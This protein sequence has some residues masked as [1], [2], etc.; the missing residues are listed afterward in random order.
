MWNKL[1]KRYLG[2]LLLAAAV[3][4]AALFFLN[5]DTKT[6]YVMR[7]VRPETGTARTVITSTGSVQP[8]NRLEIKPPIGGRIE[9]ILV[10]E[11]DRVKA[12]TVVA[13]MSSTERAALL[14]AA[15]AQ[16]AEA[17]KYWE[18]AYKPTPLLAPISGDVI[19][20]AVE[21]G[22]TVTQTDAVVVLSDRLIIKAQMD[23][24]DIGRVRLG[25][26][27]LISLD[28]YPEIS[29]DA[30]VDH[31]SFESKVVNN[32]TMYEVDVVPERVP[33]VFRSGMSA[34]VKIIEKIKENA[35]LLPREAVK[36]DSDGSFVHVRKENGRIE[37][38][39]VVTGI[40]EDG[41]MEITGGLSLDDVVIIRSEPSAAPKRA[42]QSNPLVPFSRKKN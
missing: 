20:R 23:E 7:E 42:G 1:R 37:R 8:Q 13:L 39:P 40:A 12:G 4:I 2:L 32:V 9:K 10:R 28:A 38:L 16:G 36:Q 31:I 5:R 35:L 30:R 25:Q 22:Q 34:T 18:D 24:T 19:V 3:V 29:V 14:D 27:A 41:R 6:A 11:G 26:K 21:P 17:I 15:R 33:D